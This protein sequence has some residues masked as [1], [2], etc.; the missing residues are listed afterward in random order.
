MTKDEHGLDGID[1]AD[2]TWSEVNRGPTEVERDKSKAAAV[3]LSPATVPN[4]ASVPEPFRVCSCTSSQHLGENRL[5][6]QRAHKLVLTARSHWA[7]E[8]NVKKW[9]EWQTEN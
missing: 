5:H 2:A 4:I 3:P 1:C 6:R 8:P 7:S 9:N